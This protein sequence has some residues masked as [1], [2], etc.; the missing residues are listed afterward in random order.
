MAPTLQL[1]YTCTAA[2]LKEAQELNLHRHCKWRSRV[3]NFGLIAFIAVALYF[4][5]KTQ[6]EPKDRIWFVGIVIVV[7]VALQILKR[8]VQRPA[9]DR[10]RL[11]VSEQELVFNSSTGRVVRP[12]PTFSQCLESPTLFVLLDRTKHLL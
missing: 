3:I 2:E 7:F 9:N 11:E 8:K 10:L 4:K 5:F 1:E 12:W 6:I